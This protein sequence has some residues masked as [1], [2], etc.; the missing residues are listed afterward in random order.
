LECE[1]RVCVSSTDALVIIII[2]CMH[3]SFLFT[4]LYNPAIAAIPNKAFYHS[5]IIDGVD[6]FNLPPTKEEVNAFAGVCLSVCLLA[7]LS[8]LLKT[9]A[10][11]WKKCA[12]RCRDMDE[13]INF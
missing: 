8:R 5:I 11:I 9:R 10:W 3:I 6:H 1:W 2:Y 13:L 4:V 7:R 12:D